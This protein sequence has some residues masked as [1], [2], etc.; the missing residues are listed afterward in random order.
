MSGAQ[1][2]RGCKF[3]CKSLN[4][5]VP[6]LESPPS[7][8]GDWIKIE[9]DLSTKQE[10]FRMSDI[11]GQNRFEVVGR[12]QEIWKWADKHTVDGSNIK[13][14]KNDIDTLAGHQ[15]FAESMRLVGWLTGDDNGLQFPNFQRHNGSSAKARALEAEAKRLRR[16][17]E[18]EQEICPTKKAQN[19]RP[20]KRREEKSIVGKPE[21]TKSV[22]QK[23]M[24]DEDWFSWLKDKFPGI[25]IEEQRAKAEVWLT[26]R[27]GRQFTRKFFLGWLFRTEKPIAAKPK[28]DYGKNPTGPFSEGWSPE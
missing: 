5:N 4:H 28:P 16:L 9:H 21:K 8:A 10:V 2:I 18:N 3:E 15:G 12:L 17:S 25:D 19:V 23:T 27:P 13:M 26:L 6:P 20:E 22:K 24:N 1:D 14:T 11:V 7:M